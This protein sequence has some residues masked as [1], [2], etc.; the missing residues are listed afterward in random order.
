M[1]LPNNQT[2]SFPLHCR[3]SAARCV[4]NPVVITIVRQTGDFGRLPLDRRKTPSLI[5]IGDY[6]VFSDSHTE[7]MAT[8][9]TATLITH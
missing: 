8:T 4:E 6:R 7:R 9:N 1:C 3:H 2:G 5:P